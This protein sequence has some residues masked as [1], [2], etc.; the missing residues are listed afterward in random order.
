MMQKVQKYLA[1]LY[2]NLF[3]LSELI[4]RLIFLI[5]KMLIHI[6]IKYK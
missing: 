2:T 3:D 6:Y 4:K 1:F 5:K